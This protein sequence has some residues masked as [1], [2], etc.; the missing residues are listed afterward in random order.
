MGARLDALDDDEKAFYLWYLLR[1][2]YKVKLRDEKEKY[3]N[4]RTTL[5]QINRL[6]NNVEELDTLLCYELF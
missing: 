1:H 5:D 4:D 2:F 3:E 6:L